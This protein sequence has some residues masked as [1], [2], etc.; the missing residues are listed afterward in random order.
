MKENF[1]QN[2]SIREDLE[3]PHPP[4]QEK[5]QSKAEDFEGEQ[6]IINED[7]KVEELPELWNSLYKEYLGLVPK[8]DTEGILQDVHWSYG[9]F[10]YFPTYTLGN[11]YAAQFRNKMQDEIDI[12]NLAGEGKLGT[13]LSWQREHIHR[14]GSLYWPDEL[15]RRVTKESLNP[16]YF[17]DY[18]SNKYTQI[19][20]L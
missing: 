12:D 3:H 14:Y 6:K 15:I 20:S 1:E 17:I 8:T 10:G 18:L 19:Y 4:E 9:A 16:L 11:L 13:I 2:I 7:I 5:Y